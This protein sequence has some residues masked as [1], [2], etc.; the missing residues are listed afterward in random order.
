MK[1]GIVGRGPWG[2]VYARNLWAMGVDFWQAGRDYGLRSA[3]GVIVA[4][5]PHAHFAVAR[6]FITQGIPVLIEKPVCLSS[7]DARDLLAVAEERRVSVMVS[8]TRLYSPAWR[9]FK[10]QALAAGVR[11]VYAEAG[12]PCKL[13]PL[14]DWGP[15]LAAMGFDLG[16]RPKIYTTADPRPLLV[17]VNGR[18]FFNDPPTVPTPLAAMLTEFMALIATQE[19]RLDD[20]RLGLRVVE[21]LEGVEDGR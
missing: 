5:A 14:W 8:H 4:C 1:L 6:D 13:S 17:V 7:Q 10:A 2:D 21:F 11:R 20:L 12:G 16:V 19:H 15:H 18:L 9:D 3:D